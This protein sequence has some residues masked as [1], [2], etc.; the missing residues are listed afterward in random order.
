MLKTIA[1]FFGGLFSSSKLQDTAIDGLRKIGGLD[2]L[3]GKE[4]S[5]FILAY[6]AASKHQSPTRR[7]IAIMM[8]I[9]FAIFAATWLITTIAMYVY[10]FLGGSPISADSLNLLRGD[11]FM[12]CKEILLQPVNI[13]ISFYFIV[14]AAKKR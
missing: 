9:G 13:I 3:N 7:F 2:E 14:D 1:S 5:E 11:I 4:K 12:M 6:I 10:L 8:S